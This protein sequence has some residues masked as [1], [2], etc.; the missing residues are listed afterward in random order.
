MFY[1]CGRKSENTSPCHLI[2]MLVSL[3]SNSAY[4]QHKTFNMQHIYIFYFTYNVRVWMSKLF[5][6]RLCPLVRHQPLRA[7]TLDL[8][9]TQV[10]S[11]FPPIIAPKEIYSQPAT[12][13]K[14]ITTIS[15]ICFSLIW[16]YLQLAL[17]IQRFV[18]KCLLVNAL[19]STFSVFIS[20]SMW[21]WMRAWWKCQTIIW[22]E[23]CKRYTRASA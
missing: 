14:E 23:W 1:P 16:I 10:T 20:K 5:C 8:T 21:W 6:Q 12:K 4:K 13:R 2:W 7:H 17:C 18:H 11:Y 9:H 19:K 3:V 22:Y 15:R